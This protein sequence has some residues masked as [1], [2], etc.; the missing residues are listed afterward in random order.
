MNNPPKAF[1]TYSHKDKTAKERLLT[2]L[3][4]MIQ[5]EKIEIWHDN[6][7]LAGDKWE[8]AISNKL[9]GSDILLYLTSASSLKSKNCNK[10]LLNALKG[11]AIRLIPI[12]LEA[13]D[14]LDSDHELSNFQALPTDGKPINKWNPRSDGWQNVVDGIR[15]IINEDGADDAPVGRKPPP[16]GPPPSGGQ[17][18][19]PSMN[20][21]IIFEY[22]NF[23]M[24]LGQLNR[25]IESY[26]EAIKLDPNN[27]DAYNNRGIAYG[28]KGEHDLAI[29]DFNKAIDLN[30]NSA[31]AYGNRG[32]VHFNKGEYDRTISDFSKAI[33]LNP[34]SAEVYY[35]RGN[36]YRAKGE[37]SSAIA[38]YT[39]AIELKPNFADAY[40]NRGI[41][42]KKYDLA[43]SDLTKAIDL[44]PG[45]AKTYCNRG[46]THAANG[47]LNLA[48][49]DYT[50]AIELESGF[51]NVYYDR[52]I[53][54]L[55]LGNSK[56]A[57]TDLTTAQ[58]LGFDIVSAFQRSFGNIQKFEQIY[59][60][61]IPS[62]ICNLLEPSN[63]QKK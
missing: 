37:S 1:I 7:M 59:K 16:G 3:D 23:S 49:Q 20:I 28:K 56:N 21:T 6:K 25:A 32:N 51:T 13:C 39:K 63:S 58:S 18:L 22:G 10:E 19:S 2:Q 4:V 12:I 11:K 29:K 15:R 57:K 41:V 48:I 55:I 38:D 14:W 30:P 62:N 33:D 24:M 43:I 53:V 46:N 52:G 54:M 50:K 45:D 26:S 40:N 8:D 35:N 42:Y 31:N 44:E 60:V 34:D 5:K 17:T 61:T 9:S 27:A 36:A 47:R